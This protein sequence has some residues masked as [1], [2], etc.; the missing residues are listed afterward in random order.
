MKPSSWSMESCNIDEIRYFANYD[1]IRSRTTFFAFL[2]YLAEQNHA[3]LVYLEHR[4]YGKSRPT[5]L[6]NECLNSD[7]T[8]LSTEQVLADTANLIAYFKKTRNNPSI[9]VF[10]CGYAGSLA[11]WFRLKYEHLCNGAVAFN[12]PLELKADYSGNCQRC[13]SDQQSYSLTLWLA[14]EAGFE[15]QS[16]RVSVQTKVFSNRLLP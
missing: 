16:C 10:G 11:V 3:L 9:V 12:A 5:R 14:D 8:W 6:V 2:E 13:L 7:L 15:L 4:Y 1:C